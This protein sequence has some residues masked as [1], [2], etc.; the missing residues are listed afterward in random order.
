MA[1]TGS[2]SVGSGTTV[3]PDV[4]LA[5]EPAVSILLGGMFVAEEVETPE[6]VPDSE[7]LVVES[8]GVVSISFL[9]KGLF[10]EGKVMAGMA[11]AIGSW[12]PEEGW[13]YSNAEEPPNS[14]RPIPIVTSSM[15]CTLFSKTSEKVSQ[16]QSLINC[17]YANSCNKTGRRM[18][19]PLQEKNGIFNYL[20]T[21]PSSTKSRK[22]PRPPRSLSDG[23]SEKPTD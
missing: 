21:S 18:H 10:G 12:L 13:W 19:N 5:P 7:E 14:M 11:M 16:S 6:P 9:L 8:G 23:T 3:V 17:S 1:S 20:S 4:T 15:L 22:R 2:I